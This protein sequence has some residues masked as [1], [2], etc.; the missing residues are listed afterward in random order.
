LVPNTRAKC[1]C[2]EQSPHSHAQPAAAPR[3]SQTGVIISGT[4]PAL[5]TVCPGAPLASARR[6]PAAPRL[7]W[8]TLRRERGPGSRRAAKPLGPV[9]SE[10]HAPRAPSL[11]RPPRRRH[12]SG[13]RAPERTGAP[14]GVAALHLEHL[15]CSRL[16]HV[17]GRSST[18][19]RSRRR[20]RL[21]KK[22]L[23]AKAVWHGVS[24]AGLLPVRRGVSTIGSVVGGD[25]IRV[26]RGLWGALRGQAQR[27]LVE[28]DEP[29]RQYRSPQAATLTNAKAPPIQYDLG[30]LRIIHCGWGAKTRGCR[31]VK[32]PPGCSHP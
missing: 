28:G 27:P 25:A 4:G 31:W 30:W 32:K 20:A 21:A 1:T 5:P 7:R 11:E 6:G 14:A 16:R 29:L 2:E 9:G 3:C 10:R 15:A 26:L 24:G 19:E 8:P 22:H 18:S 23:E 12:G 17:H 13:E